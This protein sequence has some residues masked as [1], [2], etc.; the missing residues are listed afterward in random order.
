MRAAGGA[1]N[2]D[3]IS[4]KP[5]VDDG[6]GR[7]FGVQD[8]NQYNGPIGGGLPPKSTGKRVHNQ[9]STS[10]YSNVIGGSYVAQE[11]TFAQQKSSAN[12]ISMMYGAGAGVPPIQHHQID[13][14]YG[15]A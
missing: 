15:G 12:P 13:M 6:K 14:M 1:I 2:L 5:S 3:S 7:L 10:S 11:D 9:G 8:E 4:K